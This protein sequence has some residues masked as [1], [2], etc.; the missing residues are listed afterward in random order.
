MKKKIKAKDRFLALLKVKGFTLIKLSK[1][2]DIT[3]S[4]QALRMLSSQRMGVT[5]QNALIIC[6]VTGYDFDDLFELR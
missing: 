3:I 5:Y 4:L 2:Q 6:Q 1:H